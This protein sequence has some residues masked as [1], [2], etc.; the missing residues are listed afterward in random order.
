ML[1][2]YS[3]LKWVLYK[4][5]TQEVPNCRTTAGNKMFQF[6]FDSFYLNGEENFAQAFEMYVEKMVPLHS[7][8]KCF[9]TLLISFYPFTILL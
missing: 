8:I 4:C 7:K 2:I 9:K 5:A 1:K 3:C 6:P